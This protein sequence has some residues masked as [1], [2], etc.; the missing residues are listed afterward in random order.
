VTQNEWIEKLCS[1]V[2]GALKRARGIA[3]LSAQS[4]AEATNALGYPVTRS[5]IANY[6]N[7]RT[8]SLDVATLLTLASAL[9][10]PPVLLLFPG[11][12]DGE[13]EVLPG[14][15]V[16]SRQAVEWFSG[17]ARMPGGDSPT[18]PGIE[19]IE[20]IRRYAAEEEGL[21]GVAEL[22]K[23]M[24]MSDASVARMRQK[25]LDR[26]LDVGQKITELQ[27]QLEGES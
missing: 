27:K 26:M 14:R 6:E 24:D 25:Q 7:G 16:T 1:K 8:R 17:Q 21:L 18:N 12:P 9:N 22:A 13:V 2:V 11:Y 10:V 20:A 15:K 4:V 3:G 5:Q 23:K 19:I